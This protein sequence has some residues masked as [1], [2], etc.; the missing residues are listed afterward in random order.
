MQESMALL[1]DSSITDWY[2]F[3]FGGNSTPENG[4]RYGRKPIIHTDE[5]GDPRNRKFFWETFRNVASNPIGRNLLYRLLIEVHRKDGLE[6]KIAQKCSPNSDVAV[7]F[8]EARE[9]A[10]DLHVEWT[11]TDFSIKPFNGLLCFN[12]KLCKIQYCRGVGGRG[13]YNI[14]T[15]PSNINVDLFHEL[16]HW[17]HSLRHPIRYFDEK[18]GF[19]P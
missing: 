15:G 12:E 13:E 17:F 1:S 2:V 7:I 19:E 18:F 11:D 10:L 4:Q 8:K 6:E 3:M 9:K 16:L 14:T 5:I